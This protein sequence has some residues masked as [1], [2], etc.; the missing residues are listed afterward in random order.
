MSVLNFFSK[1]EIV[2]LS[3]FIFES[4]SHI[5]VQNGYRFGLKQL[6]RIIKIEDNINGNADKY[7]L[8]IFNGEE[9]N[10]LWG[11]NVQLSPKPMEIVRRDKTE[12]ELRGYGYDRD[13]VLMGVPKEQAS[14]SDYGITIYHSDKGVIKKCIV[15]WFDRNVDIEY[16]PTYNGPDEQKVESVCAKMGVLHLAQVNYGSYFEEHAVADLFSKLDGY[17]FSLSN[18]N[19]L[20]IKRNEDVVLISQ[21]TRIEEDQMG[22]V[23]KCNYAICGDFRLVCISDWMKKLGKPEI[24]TFGSMRGDGFA[25]T[26]ELL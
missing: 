15:H 16:Y 1:K 21:C 9:E 7:T 19:V 26:F 10:P 18:Q 5:R 20:V 23:Y 17:I 8:T 14:F 12:I 22:V 24:I 4:K 2:I 25:V 3:N 6:K 11:N 13:A